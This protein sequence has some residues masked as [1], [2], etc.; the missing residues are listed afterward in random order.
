MKR[1]L[2][3]NLSNVYKILSDLDYEIHSLDD[4]Y[5]LNKFIPSNSYENIIAIKR[6]CSLKN[7]L[8]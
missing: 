6:N 4:N 1:D 3:T 7:Y 2:N 8:K 5:L